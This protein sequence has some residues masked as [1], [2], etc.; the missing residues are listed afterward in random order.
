MTWEALLALT[1]W[2]RCEPLQVASP[3]VFVQY[4]FDA[5]SWK[6]NESI[7]KNADEEVKD[8]MVLQH[9]DLLIESWWRRTWIC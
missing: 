3:S 5:L 4:R 2:T 6:K 1:A 7:D 8:L 9:M